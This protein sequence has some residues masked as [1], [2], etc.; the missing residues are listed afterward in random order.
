MF[1]YWF[2]R[3]WYLN[4][5]TG[6]LTTSIHFALQLCRI[7][8]SNCYP[9][10]CLSLAT[11]FGRQFTEKQDKRLETQRA[12]LSVIQ[13]VETLSKS[14]PN[15]VRNAREDYFLNFSSLTG[16][17]KGPRP[18]FTRHRVRGAQI[19]FTGSFQRYI[20]PRDAAERWAVALNVRPRNNLYSNVYTYTLCA[21]TRE[22]EREGE[23][24][25]GGDSSWEA[26]C[27]NLN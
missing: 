18:L 10:S 2:K 20:P 3:A 12:V 24:G 7:R 6:V 8:L 27:L 19:F 5:R 13:R 17:P 15:K 9:R 25:M 23:R 16:I 14:P 26:L 22:W 11:R 21:C 4:R 1:D